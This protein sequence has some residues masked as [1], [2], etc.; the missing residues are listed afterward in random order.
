M[1][2]NENVVVEISGRIYYVFGGW[3]AGLHGQPAYRIRY[4]YYHGEVLYACEYYYVKDEM[5][6]PYK[7]CK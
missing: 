2:S 7:G 6:M 5:K 1:K 4:N 3:P